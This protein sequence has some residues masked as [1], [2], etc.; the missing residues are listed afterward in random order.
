MC[1]GVVAKV[2]DVKEYSAIVDVMGASMEVGTIFLE[3]VN[4]ADYVIVHAGQALSTVN[5]QAALE[6]LE[7]WTELIAKEKEQREASLQ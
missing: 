7:T 2:V 1:I 6:S 3:T 4:V 5:E